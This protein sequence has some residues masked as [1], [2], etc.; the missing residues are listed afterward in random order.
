MNMKRNKEIKGTV[1]RRM[2][3]S[4]LLLLTITFSAKGQVFIM[5][6]DAGRNG[7]DASDVNTII[8]LHNVEYDQENED[9]YVPLGGGSL[10]LAGLGLCYLLKKNKKD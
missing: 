5:G 4:M 10:L 1:L 6:E 7:T 2:A 8:P 3:M 9:I